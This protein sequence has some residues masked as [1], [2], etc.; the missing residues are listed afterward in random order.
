MERVHA[1]PGRGIDLARFAGMF[2][3]RDPADSS[4]LERLFPITY[5][6]R[7]FALAVLA[8]ALP[9]RVWS[10]PDLDA[11]L[12]AT[13]A[14]FCF[15]AGALT[16][17]LLRESCRLLSARAH[18]KLVAPRAL[19][20]E[21]DDLAPGWRAGRRL[22]FRGAAAEIVQE[23]PPAGYQLVRIDEELYARSLWPEM[24]H[25]I[26][27]AADDYVRHH[28][29]YCLLRDGR[30]AAEAHGVVGGGLVELGLF[31]HPEHRGRGLTRVVASALFRRGAARGL[32]PAIT[33][34]V[35][36]QESRRIAERYLLTDGPYETLN[37][38][39]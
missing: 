39:T 1:G 31:T 33:C 30:I 27:G 21:P 11:C 16:P 10:T 4:A 19:P 34:E 20:A 18:V 7:A 35:G 5:P 36:R 24:V 17:A 32:V 37:L 22:H 29:G 26:Y 2:A 12:V 13:G 8:G 23:E 38:Q 28:E 3:E 15:A 25:A 9:G 6:N 14:P